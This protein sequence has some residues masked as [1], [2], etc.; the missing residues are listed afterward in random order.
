MVF[1]LSPRVLLVTGLFIF[2]ISSGGAPRV[3]LAESDE[4]VDYV[5]LAERLYADGHIERAEQTL[6]RVNVEDASVDKK[7]FYLVSGLI[8]LQRKAYPRATQSFIAAIKAG[9]T[10][11][12]VYLGLGQ[13]Y[14]HQSK[15]EGALNALR[16]ASPLFG[17]LSAGYLMAAECYWSLGQPG[18]ALLV[19]TLAEDEFPEQINATRQRILYLVELGLSHEAIEVSDRL[20]RH[21]N[22]T[23]DDFIAVA[24][25]L[26]Q[27]KQLYQVVF[28][29]EQARVY[30]PSSARIQQLLAHAYLDLGKPYAAALLF[31]ALTLFDTENA[32]AAAQAFKA[33]RRFVRALS[34]NTK[35]PDPAKRYTQRL[36]ILV[37]AGRFFEVAA[38]EATLTRLGLLENDEIRY[39]LAYAHFKSAVGQKAKHHLRFI[40]DVALLDQVSAL[41]R[42]IAVCEESGWHC[43]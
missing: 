7:A 35:V 4:G 18:S 25:A 37:D 14:F 41:R 30:R 26:R 3:A 15:Y 19:L 13:A 11:A 38:M 34:Q 42:S 24:Q 2:G 27:A 8:A 9:E 16:E 22:V 36:S 39:A 43:L 20:M 17:G 28:L 31:E 21:E 33:A 5:G 12:M 1:C 10:R 6:R 23:E 40:E 32:Y 29:L